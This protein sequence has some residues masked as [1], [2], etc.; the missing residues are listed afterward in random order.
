MGDA[1]LDSNQT[2]PTI[3]LFDLDGT[4]VNHINPRVL[5]ALEFL[6]DCSH[7]AARLVARFRLMRRQQTTP[8]KMPKLLVHRAIHRV[9]RKSVDQM[10][11]PCETMRRVLERLHENGVILGLV[12]NGL[13]RGYG[14]DVLEAFD[15]RKYFTTCVFREDVARGKPWPDSIQAALGN[16]GRGLRAR[17][18]VWY[19]GDQRKDVDAALSASANLSRAIVPVAL[20]ARAALR[21]MDG[22]CPQ[23]QIAWSAHDLDRL[24]SDLFDT[25]L[26]GPVR[27]PY[28][29]AVA[30]A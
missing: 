5:Q 6:D 3:V 23:L 2:P 10:L 18:V 29:L 7:R 27:A 20:G 25:H 12:S 22:D 19:V 24:T 26:Y 16:V 11:V 21:A 13:G 9:R 1:T 8:C 14:H 28:P 15:L 4:L 30:T 17:D